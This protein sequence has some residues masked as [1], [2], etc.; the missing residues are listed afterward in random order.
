MFS[1]S[2]V[3]YL[4]ILAISTPVLSAPVPRDFPISGCPTCLDQ[5]FALYVYFHFRVKE[6]K[7]IS[8]VPFLSVSFRLCF[9]PPG[10]FRFVLNK[11][12]EELKFTISHSVTEISLATPTVGVEEAGTSPG[13]LNFTVNSPHQW[14]QI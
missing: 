3:F 14:Q 7:R 6:F 12:G 10:K 1:T 13:Y 8:I 4:A 11:N 9:H 2:T 5:D